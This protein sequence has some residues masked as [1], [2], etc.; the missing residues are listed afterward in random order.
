[1]TSTAS[2]ISVN[3]SSGAPTVLQTLPEPNFSVTASL[4]LP[5][6]ATSHALGALFA[7]TTVAASVVPLAFPVAREANGMYALEGFEI[8][9]PVDTGFTGMPLVMKIYELS[10][11][12]AVGDAGAWLANTTFSSY[13]GDVTVV[14][15][16]TFSNGLA[17]VGTPTK[18]D[19]LLIKCDASSQFYALPVAGATILPSAGSRT[20]NFRP[21]GFAL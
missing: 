6:S 21:I 10:P 19:R 3:N 18:F 16:Q 7:S 17:G 11:T 5:A 15:D 14:M 9:M 8:D 12:C 20:L 1:M 13:R 4:T 2:R